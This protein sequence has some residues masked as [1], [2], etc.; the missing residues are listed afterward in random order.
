MES[1]ANDTSVKKANDSIE[2]DRTGAHS[3]RS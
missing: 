3:G 1:W 2:D